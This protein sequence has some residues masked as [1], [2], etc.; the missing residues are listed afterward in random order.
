MQYI[1]NRIGTLLPIT[2]LLTLLSPLVSAAE[3]NCEYLKQ[4]LAPYELPVD[5]W[6]TSMAGPP[7]GE[8]EQRLVGPE[9]CSILKDEIINNASGVPYRHV[10][11]GIS[12]T[13]F[14]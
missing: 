14:G 3:N 4:Y 8:V 2:L 1:L 10:I 9:T 7:P 13:V 12:G 5:E 11:I 6:P